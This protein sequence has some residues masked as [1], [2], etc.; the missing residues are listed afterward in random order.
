MEQ[1]YEWPN[2]SSLSRDL[3]IG[4]ARLSHFRNSR[5]ARTRT[6]IVGVQFIIQ[7]ASV[8]F[9]CTRR[10]SKK[11]EKCWFSLFATVSCA[12]RVA[13]LIFRCTI[14]GTN[15]A[16]LATCTICSK[17]ITSEKCRVRPNKQNYL[18]MIIAL[19]IIDYR[20]TESY[21]APVFFWAAE[22]WFIFPRN[23]PKRTIRH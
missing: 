9:K 23:Y 7:S 14:H 11:K 21:F 18:F 10:P 3:F 16:K 19:L 4:H 13:K 6:V 20:L 2:S 15:S 22:M 17:N 8:W 1:R 12:T 5:A